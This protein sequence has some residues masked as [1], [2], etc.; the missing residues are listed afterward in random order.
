MLQRGDQVHDRLNLRSGG[1]TTHVVF[2]KVLGYKIGVQ[3]VHLG[4]AM[5]NAQVDAEVT[6]NTSGLLVELCEFFRDLRLHLSR[7][8]FQLRNIFPQLRELFASVTR[9]PGNQRWPSDE[10]TR[11]DSDRQQ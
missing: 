11:G 6:H 2:R 8:A 7:L 9:V 1:K 3:A 4:F 5:H 10:Q